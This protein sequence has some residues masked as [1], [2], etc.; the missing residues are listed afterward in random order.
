MELV[1]T[2]LRDKN[3]SCADTSY[4]PRSPSK[5]GFAALLQSLNMHECPKMFM[6]G[7]ALIAES[8]E[9]NTC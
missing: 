3:A 4:I 8:S 5:P 6:L 7:H 9:L 2:E 1:R